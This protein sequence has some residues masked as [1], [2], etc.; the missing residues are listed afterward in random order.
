MAQLSVSAQGD[1]RERK[2]GS[3]VNATTAELCS[4]CNTRKLCAVVNCGGVHEFCR[5]C[6]EEWLFRDSRCP[7]CSEDVTMFK[8]G[9]QRIKVEHKRQPTEPIH[10]NPNPIGGNPSRSRRRHRDEEENVV[11]DV[12]DVPDDEPIP[13]Q[14]EAA[15]EPDA[16]PQEEG[17]PNQAADRDAVDRLRAIQS[18]L[19][20]AR[21]YLATAAALVRAEDLAS[22]GETAAEMPAKIDDFGLYR[23]T[24]ASMARKMIVKKYI[25]LGRQLDLLMKKHTEVAS[26]RY[27]ERVGGPHFERQQRVRAEADRLEQVRRENDERAKREIQQLRESL[28]PPRSRQRRS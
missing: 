9:G 22:F 28:R 5:I 23:A 18:T 1:L 27:I 14:P 8:T 11:G 15:A 10:E 3:S 17:L 24:T 4:I 19:L 12:F 6:A 13:E 7:L 21:E 25:S 20:V 2:D 26:R 16:E